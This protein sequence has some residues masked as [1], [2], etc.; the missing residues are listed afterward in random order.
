MENI[1]RG[2]SKVQDPE[3]ARVEEISRK[4]KAMAEASYLT[5]DRLQAL[6]TEHRVTISTKILAKQHADGEY[7]IEIPDGTSQKI[8]NEYNP[9]GRSPIRYLVYYP[10]E[11]KTFIS[12]VP[13][14]IEL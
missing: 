3:K 14:G 1:E 11:K 7:Y 4:L 8:E 13:K 6:A 2:S 5:H 12:K 9:S 10:G